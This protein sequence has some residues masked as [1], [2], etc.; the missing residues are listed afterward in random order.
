MRFQLKPH[1]FYIFIVDQR[2]VKLTK[3]PR[4]SVS[5]FFPTESGGFII[6]CQLHP[7]NHQPVSLLMPKNSE[8]YRHFFVSFTWNWF[9]IKIKNK[10]GFSW[11]FIFYIKQA[12]KS[13]VTSLLQFHYCR[14][15]F[16]SPIYETTVKS[17]VTG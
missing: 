3:T 13:H 1:L 2:H 15:E 10:W 16:H 12:I 7:W 4:P 6:L 9:T 8:K 11:N 5:I 14:V 17:S